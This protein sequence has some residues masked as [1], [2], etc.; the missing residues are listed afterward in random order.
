MGHPRP[1]IWLPHI[2]PYR[3]QGLRALSATSALQLHN[4]IQ[5]RR[6]GEP[7]HRRSSGFF[8]IHAKPLNGFAN[9]AGQA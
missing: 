9:E 3:D 5:R 4:E 8:R 2:A 7:G 6:S 1:F